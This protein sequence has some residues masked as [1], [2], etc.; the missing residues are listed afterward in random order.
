[1]RLGQRMAAAML[2]A[3][4]SA[5][6]LV[7]S[8]QAM[9]QTPPARVL[10][11]ATPADAATLDPHATNAQQTFL[12]VAQMYQGLTHRGDD[13]SIQPGLAASWEQVEPLRWRFRLRDGVRFHGGEAFDAEDVAFSIGRARA[14]TS[15]YG[16]FVDTVTDVTVVDR[17]T[18]DI[19]TRVPDAALPSKFTRVLMMDRGWSEA[20][21][22]AQPQNFSQR[23][24]MH[25]VR[26]A[27]G[28]GPFSLRTR[29][30]DQRTVL[31]RNPAWWGWGGPRGGGNV[32]EYHHLTVAN[33]AT[34]VAALLSGDVDMV[35]VVPSQ[36]VERLRRAPR[37]QV[38]DG[39]ENRTAFL[40]FRQDLEELPGIPGRNPWRDLRVRQAVAHA[41]DME[42]IRRTAM[43]GLAVPTGSMWPRYVEG[44]SEAL[45]ARLP[46]DPDRARRL[47]AEAGFADGFT[48]NFLC[49][50]G[51]YDE[52]CRAM[53]PM[54]ARIGIR[55]QLELLTVPPYIG[56]IQR[57]E[58]SL[59][60]LNWGVQTF[61]PM[62]IFRAVMV[63]R[64]A[65]GAASWNAGGWINDRFDQLVTEI[66][67]E[68]DVP[69]RRALIAEAHALHNAEIGHL[70]LF[71]MVNVWAARQGLALTHRADHHYDVATM[72]LD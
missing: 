72:R 4:L 59:Y 17:L 61:D 3:G 39:P 47:M 56:R 68:V 24:E 35:H 69:R 9:A 66:E 55:A 58:V 10:R 64:A 33:D 49:P 44:W 53:V 6:P 27:N 51:T 65:G 15:N 7:L 19:T 18:V 5:I 42:T 70:P 30:Q 63:S 14:P 38:T 2:A 13:L 54:L 37:V 32:T 62:F 22:A 40:G 11:T 71:H 1:M 34:R 16:V 29:E 23:E 41:I 36:D 57:R 67:R 60:G 31:V 12:L 26:N 21:R 25:T 43:R 28:T 48:T 50:I 8:C 52:A 45:E 20:N 46:Y